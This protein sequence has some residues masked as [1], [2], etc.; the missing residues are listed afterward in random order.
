MSSVFKKLK[1]RHIMADFDLEE[2]EEQ[3]KKRLKTGQN[4]DTSEG[5]D[6]GEV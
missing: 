3:I 2:D 5:S 1:E 6:K 4:S